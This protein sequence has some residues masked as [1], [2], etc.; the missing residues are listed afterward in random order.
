VTP[1]EGLLAAICADPDQDAP[2]LVYADWLEETGRE[3][4]AEFVRLQLRLVELEKAPNRPAGGAQLAGWLWAYH[5]EMAV[6]RAILEETGPCPCERCL[7]DRE[8]ELLDAHGAGWFLDFATR[9]GCEGGYIDR[10]A[11]HYRIRGG[12][13]G[14]CEFRRGFVESVTCPAAAWAGHGDAVLAAQPVTR[15]TLTGP[16]G[17]IEWRDRHRVDGPV[18][19]GDHLTID[20]GTGRFRL[21]EAGEPLFAAALKDAANGWVWSGTLRPDPA[22][23]TPADDLRWAA[24]AFSSPEYLPPE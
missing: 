10:N 6:M 15:L 2:R 21:R 4:R 17:R 8:R 13:L 19:A 1:D 23:W 20:R 9:A 16:S 3:A 11:W 18:S 14:W 24:T 12:W 22:A 7:R 5:R